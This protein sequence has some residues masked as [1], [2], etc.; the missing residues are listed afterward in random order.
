MCCYFSD[1]RELAGEEHHSSVSKSRDASSFGGDGE[2]N[3]TQHKPRA[4][5]LPERVGKRKR[6]RPSGTIAGKQKPPINRPLKSRPRAKKPAKISEYES[7]NDASLNDKED[8]EVSNVASGSLDKV[9]TRTRA[10]SNQPRRTG[11]RLI[12]K[13]VKIT[14]NESDEDGAVKE[15]TSDENFK[16]STTNETEAPKDHISDRGKEVE[17]VVAESS[18]HTQ[19]LDE[20]NESGTGQS[21]STH[22]IEDNVDP[23]QAMLMD[24]IPMLARKKV[25]IVE[26]VREEAK[27][28]APDPVNEEAE[29][30]KDA[31]MQTV[32]KRKVSYKDM[33]AQLLKDW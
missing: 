8:F 22:L 21:S 5:T 27:I 24:M 18:N 1:E 4:V 10:G 2:H 17:K 3:A 12:S 14:E 13:P 16:L 19:K 15:Q 11:A 23:I 25:E 33:A 32:K 7:D 26:P 29:V 28:R 31:E 20:V 9:D 6:G 30:A